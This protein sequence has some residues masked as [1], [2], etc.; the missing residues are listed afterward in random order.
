MRVIA[1][2]HKGR[3]LKGVSGRDIRPTAD[4]VRESIF[5]ILATRIEGARVLD[6]FGGT[7]A[8]GI[9]ALSRGADTVVFVDKAKS[10]CDI[11]RAN[12]ELVKESAEVQNCDAMR[13]LERLNGQFDMVFI[14]PPYAESGEQCIEKIGERK[15]L[16]CN[17]VIVY[18]RN[19]KDSVSEEIG[20][21]KV[22]DSRRYGSVALYFYK[23]K[24][25]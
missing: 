3:T 9:E 19:A 15:L 20:E 5:N 24:S 18:E 25:V 2:K 21:L 12:L 6:I 23:W 16:A 13:A 8:M 1:G 7:G 4:N 11:I 14:D 17:G 22:A 10:S